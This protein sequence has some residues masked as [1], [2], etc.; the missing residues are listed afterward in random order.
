M[1]IAMPQLILELSL[2]LSAWKSIPGSSLAL[3]LNPSSG[4]LHPTEAHLILPELPGIT[5]GIFH[6]NSFLHALEPRAEV[7]E[8]TW[9]HIK[10]HLQADG[11]LV[12]LTSILWREAWKYGERAFRYWRKVKTRESFFCRRIRV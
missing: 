1:D 6:Y 3:R 8:T 5:V 10:G 9:R 2:G 4:N 7:L 12:A 11:F